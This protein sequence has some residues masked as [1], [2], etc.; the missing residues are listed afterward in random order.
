MT[1]ANHLNPFFSTIKSII[2]KDPPLKK[3]SLKEC[4]VNLKPWLTEGI[5]TSINNKNNT[6][7][8]YCLARDQNRKNEFHTF[9]K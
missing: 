8:K 3:M 6:Y 2:D 9:F 7:Q 5:L 1:L 4:K